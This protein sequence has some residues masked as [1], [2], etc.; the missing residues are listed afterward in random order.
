M[1]IQTLH[2]TAYKLYML[3]HTNCTCYCVQIV[4]VTAYKGTVFYNHINCLMMKKHVLSILHPNMVVCYLYT[5]VL[6]CHSYV[7]GK[8]LGHLG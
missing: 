2:V 8:W 7:L 6:P 4:H 1:Y 3:L 5:G